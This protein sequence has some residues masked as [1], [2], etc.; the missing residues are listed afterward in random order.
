MLFVHS[1]QN[2][3]SGHL[4]QL[5]NSVGVNTD[6]DEF[7]QCQ[8]Q[9][10]RAGRQFTLAFLSTRTSH[11]LS[12]VLNRSCHPESHILIN[13]YPDWSPRISDQL[14]TIGMVR[15]PE[16]SHRPHLGAAMLSTDM[17]HVLWAN[18]AAFSAILDRW[19]PATLG[20]TFGMKKEAQTTTE[21][22]PK[23]LRQLRPQLKRFRHSFHLFDYSRIAGGWRYWQ[24]VLRHAGCLDTSSTPT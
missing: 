19:L 23:C 8:R 7:A 24:Y 16:M 5:S 20:D 3:L 15:A 11:M 4:R 2:Q 14:D 10:Y 6:A 1:R 13:L 9:V 22:S 12:H 21:D 17:D 18:L